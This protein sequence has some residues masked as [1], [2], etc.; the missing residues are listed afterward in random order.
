VRIRRRRRGEENDAS[1]VK[2][3]EEDSDDE[4]EDGEFLHVEEEDLVLLGLVAG[5]E[6]W[7]KDEWAEGV[8]GER[9]WARLLQ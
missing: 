2:Q 5:D 1:E 9:D 3:E 7:R 6:G 8:G 4:D